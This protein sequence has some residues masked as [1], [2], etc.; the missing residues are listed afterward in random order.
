MEVFGGLN[1]GG[2]N[3][4][5]AD[6]F[7]LGT[8]G[9]LDVQTGA[10]LTISTGY[11]LGGATL[12]GHTNLA[13]GAS[14]IMASLLT[15][16]DYHASLAAG[17]GSNAVVSRGSFDCAIDSNTRFDLSLA[18]LSLDGTGI[19]QTLEVMSTD[20]GADASGL[21]RSMAGHYPIGT[22][23]IG[24]APTTVRLV[25]ARDNDNLGQL[26]CEALY[27]D[28]LRINAGSR[29]I[30]TTCRIYYN[31][32]INNGTVD[33]PENLIPLG[34]ACIGDYNQDGGIDGADVEAFFADWEVAAPGADV[35]Q[36][37]GIDGS[38]V[39]TFFERWQAGC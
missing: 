4:V 18:T 34:Q 30:N 7:L 28:T 3:A 25:D 27:I 5:T 32:L 23:E 15:R 21:D 16:V 33:V 39:D 11:V 26:T 38:D 13:L 10:A 24:S 36:D 29:L 8:R 14:L 9:T 2:T 22:L 12:D 19:E 6:A 1:A 17:L 35:N 20:I 37:G 31:T